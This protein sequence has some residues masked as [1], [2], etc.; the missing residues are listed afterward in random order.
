[1][2]DV[3]SL[4]LK[5]DSDAT[6]AKQKVDAL[7]DTLDR[8][9]KATGNGCGL[10]AVSEGMKQVDDKGSKATKTNE[11][12]AKSFATL[13]AKVTVAA[14]A[15]KKVGNTIASWMKSSMDYIENMNLFT[16]AMGEYAG[17]AK[18][19]AEEVGDL[20]GI[21]P[22]DW[23]RNQGVYMT[24]LSGFGV[25]GDR[26]ALMSQ[27]LTQLGYDISSFY[28]T[29]VADAMTKLQSGISG[30][31]EPLR[32]LG[33]DLSQAKLESVA[34]SLGIEKSVSAMNQAEKAELRYYAIMTQVT[35]AQGDMARTLE[36]PANQLRVLKAQATQAGRAL[37]DLFLPILKAILPVATAVLK[38]IA[39]LAKVIA[40]LFGGDFETGGFSA[41]LD[42][43]ADSAGGA[44][45]AIDDATGSAKKLKKELLGIDE[46]NVMA[47]P[48]GGSSGADDS[49]G[50]SGFD[51]E[52][53]TYDFIG[54]LTETKVGKIVE[55]MLAWL[56]ITE[57]I[58]SWAELID[59]RF[60][61]ILSLAGL[62]GAE[63]LLWKVSQ[64]LIGAVTALTALSA[65]PTLTILLSATLVI[66]GITMEFTGIKDAIEN[67]LNGQNF[68]EIVG[69]A[70]CTTA[71]AILLGS[72]IV[73]WIGKI[74]GAKV[75]FA[76]A[77]LG[78]KLGIGTTKA[79]GAALG[80]GIAG[81]VV[82]IPMF[83]VGIY[84]AIKNG[85][86]WLS[87]ILIGGGG[88]LTGA[89]IGMLIGGPVGAAIGALI[90]LVAGL[91]TDLVILIVQNWESICA[92]FS[93]VFTAVGQFFSG[94]WQSICDI[95]NVCAEWFD[96]N[97]IQPIV[98]FFTGLWNGISSAASDCW[99]AIVEFF[100]PAIEWFS[101]LFGN[102]WQ[103]V[104]DIFYNIGV[105]AG[106]C[107]EIIKI[108]WEVVAGW[109]DENI[110]Q[111][112]SNFFSEMWLCISTW[113]TEAWESIKSVFSTICDWIDMNII[114]PVSGF[115]SDLWEGFTD[116]ASEA[117][118]GVKDVF[119]AV[120][121]FF[122]ETFEDAWAGIVSVFSV[123]GEIF[124]DIKDGVVEAFKWVVNGL[125][126][127]INNVVAVPFNAIN[128]VLKWL[129]DIE[130]VGI[131]PFGSI[132]TITIPEIPKLASGGVVDEGQMFIA[133]EA[134][135][136]LVANV[137]N[138]SAV[139]NNDQI[140]ESV[141]RGV[142]QAVV[143]AMG[144]SGGTQ[145]VEAKVNDKV[146]FEVV[147]DQNRRET[148]RTGY[149]PLLGGV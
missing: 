44:S 102:I 139:M 45:D 121:T 12:S 60:G 89:G 41:S 116:A 83:F 131:K 15:L 1:M 146:L 47:D 120:G 68:G 69:G 88:M 26:A 3:E 7:I 77:R 110:I 112:V 96:T 73:S 59:T 126:D 38:V 33:Y 106:G 97:V 119:S 99:N 63:I 37:G 36:D 62:I 46:L 61:K 35:T 129:R 78:N 74:G 53:P 24:L 92:W 17:S 34:L 108:C 85:L 84:D 8:L 109:V 5:I 105:I 101:E 81:I 138:K 117:W 100:T 90:G 16:V 115:F 145:V 127:G 132:K 66:A 147:V 149:N 14:V 107:W 9:K 130:I 91:L 11:K 22:S 4:V 49:L 42:S 79:L 55:E 20:M 144:Q 82:G 2:A 125:I 40:R 134:G 29:D 93:G 67:G 135:P 148:M 87:G 94:L 30:E 58:D 113:A 72:L 57:D 32:R 39:S 43:A 142:Y 52:L 137:G 122:R 10:P 56:G 31:L 114:Q 70:L 133:R 25:T 86:D 23:M 111:P 50:G 19:Y 28:N 27:Q 21:D 76:F 95:W 136:E 13:A 118:Q 64:A 48:S 123:A 6:K 71:G 141:S 75:A 143:S 128:G 54:D 18:K 140:V 104:S 80:A 124:V 103:T 98:G 65:N 51:F